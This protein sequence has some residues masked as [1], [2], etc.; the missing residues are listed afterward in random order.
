MRLN[1]AGL[2]CRDLRVGVENKESC[3][4]AR[5]ANEHDITSFNNRTSILN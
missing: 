2:P 5:D 3:A 4:V 1:I